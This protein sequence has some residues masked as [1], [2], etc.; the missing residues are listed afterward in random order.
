MYLLGKRPFC[1]LELAITAILDGYLDSFLL[2]AAIRCRCSHWM[3]AL[4]IIVHFPPV[5]VLKLQVDY[6]KIAYIVFKGQ[7]K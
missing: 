7:F 5:H 2:L 6:R 3:L 4:M 1:V